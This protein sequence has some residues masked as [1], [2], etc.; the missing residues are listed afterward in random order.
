MKD[1][2]SNSFDL[3]GGGTLMITRRNPETY[4]L[5]C[6]CGLIDEY[7]LIEIGT[8]IAHC[9]KCNTLNVIG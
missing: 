2:I 4:H 3:G 1:M 7:K 9:K 6:D 5:T 8:T